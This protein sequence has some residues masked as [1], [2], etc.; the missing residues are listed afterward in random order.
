MTLILTV[1]EL[2]IFRRH[3]PRMRIVTTKG[4]VGDR[5]PPRIRASLKPSLFFGEGQFARCVV[6][7]DLNGDNCESPHL[8][9]IVIF[10]SQN[11]HGGFSTYI[12]YAK[13]LQ[14]DYF[15]WIDTGEEVAIKAV[16]WECIRANRNRTSEDFVKEVAALNYLSDGLRGR[17][18]EETHVLT[19]NIVMCNNNHLYIVMPYCDG[20]DLCM[21]VAQMEQTRLTED[22]AR[23]YFKQIL[24]VRSVGVIISAAE[25]HTKTAYAHGVCPRRCV[26]V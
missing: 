21:R 15:G 7:F 8:L 11:Q 16:S 19:A 20:G 3:P 23:F 22:A 14:R 4:M 26:S 13:R 18:I 25:Q 1:T 10:L 2:V 24:K 17:S 6:K 9:T 12:Y 5:S